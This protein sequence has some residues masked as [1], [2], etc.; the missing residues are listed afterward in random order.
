MKILH[1]LH[2]ARAEGTVRLVLDWLGQ[3]G[4]TQEV[5]VLQA[6]P[7][8][9]AEA[10]RRESSWWGIAGT[11]PMGWTKFG[12]IISRVGQVCRERDPDLVLCWT[13]GFSPWVMLGARFAGVRKLITHA[14]NPPT[15]SLMGRLQTAFSSQVIR[16]V[17][18]RMVGCS[19]YVAEGYRRSWGVPASIVR[20]AY[21]CAPV[22]QVRRRAE[23]ARHARTDAQPRLI[24]VATLENHKDHLTLLRAMPRVSRAVPGTRLWLVGEGTQ[25]EP[26]RGLVESL[27]LEETVQFL[28][29]RRD[30]PELLGQADVFVFSTT[31]E[32][33]LGIVLIEALAAGIP[34]VASDVP[35]CHEMLQGGQWGYL[36]PERDV[37]ALAEAL[38]ARLQQR[39]QR[40]EVH[41]EEYLQRFTPG[42]MIANYLAVLP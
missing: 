17:G 33:G 26:L 21:N 20:A 11:M 18:A 2:T 15:A 10:L 35:A 30:V 23:T 32:E 22:D 27:G 24:M 28:G 38:I 36:V 29:A 34:V 7:L 41:P 5:M 14:G 6:E 9:L 1:V 4:P 12:W 37:A 16:L 39:E 25:R 19:N 31:R 8:D 42:G 13:N 3:S 40:V